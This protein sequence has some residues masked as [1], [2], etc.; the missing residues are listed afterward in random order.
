MAPTA[1]TSAPEKTSVKRTT[2]AVVGGGPAGLMLGLLLARAGV[3]VTVLEKHKDFLRDFRGDTVHPTTLTALEDLGLF[4][5]FDALPHSRLLRVA[6]PMSTGEDVVMAD[7]ERLK[8][9]HPYV[10]MVPQWDLLNLL[11][12]SAREHPNFTLLV[13]HDVTDVVRE[14][15]TV[16]GVHYVSPDGAGTV[17]ADLVVACDGRSSVVRTSVGLPAKEFPVAFDVWWF[18]VP[19]DRHIGESLL[20]RIGNGKAVVT[21]PRRGYVQ[22]AYLDRKGADPRLRERGIEA[23]RRE[24]SSVLPELGDDIENLRSMDDVKTLDVRVDRLHRWSA[25]GVLCIGDAAHAM[26]PVGGVGVNLAIQDAIATARLLAEPLRDGTFGA[27]RLDAQRF[28]AGSLGDRHPQRLLTRI[29]R[30]R[31]IPTVVIQA[32]QRVMHARVLMPAIEGEIAGAPDKTLRLLRRFPA[33]TWLPAR[34][35]G[36]GPLPERVPRWAHAAKKK[37]DAQV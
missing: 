25:P 26:S 34:I 30:R 32:I 20:P 19:T 21:I 36:I 17:L 24:I 10:A 35:I 37:S 14:G 1:E 28:G 31:R 6:L 3:D 12:E 11:A 18:K 13:E 15:D 16:T 33:L 7:F 5:S 8:V 9:Q 22:I 4:E 27:Q 2:C 23:F 29:Q